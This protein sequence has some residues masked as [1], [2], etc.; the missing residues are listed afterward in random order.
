MR[1]PGTY[2]EQSLLDLGFAGTNFLYRAVPQGLIYERHFGEKHKQILLNVFNEIHIDPTFM[3]PERPLDFIFP[4]DI[5]QV[6][7]PKL[8]EEWKEQHKKQD[9]KKQICL[10]TPA[11]LHPKCYNCGGCKT[12][13]DIKWTTTRPIESEAHIAQILET[14]SESRCKYAVKLVLSMRKDC[15]IYSRTTLAHY[16]TSQFLRRSN[17][18][19]DAFYEVSKN[20]TSWTSDKGQQGW[21][22]GKWVY[23]IQFKYPVPIQEI[24]RLVPEVNSSL[25]TVRI[26]KVYESAKNLE[27]DISD[28]ILYSGTI[29]GVPIS[30][31]KDRLSNFDWNIKVAVKGMGGLETE[32]VPAPELK[33]HML[34]VQDGQNVRM[35]MTLKGNQNPYLVLSSILGKSVEYC[36]A[37][38]VFS[39]LDHGKSVDAVCQC[40][41]TLVHSYITNKVA[42][43]CQ[44][45]QARLMLKKATH[46]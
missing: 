21:F 6:T 18:L 23:D 29:T 3:F 43:L 28:S 11:N 15:E 17:L 25:R 37:V 4:S 7:E 31:I 45:C 20:T 2:V 14:I 24:Q 13:K 36:Y 32:S 26:D 16:I 35:V 5:I 40:G 30:R 9:F 19:C 39:V 34:M 41:D 8:L 46:K 1:G 27:P 12:P 22:G 33:K 44:T 38:A 42:P 10:K